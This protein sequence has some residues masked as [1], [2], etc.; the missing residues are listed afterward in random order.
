MRV[1]R[2]GR[3]RR[4]S[5]HSAELIVYTYD[6]AHRIYHTHAV[7]RDASASTAGVLTIA[8]NTWTYPWKDSDNGKPVYVRILNVFR[9]PNTIFTKKFRWTRSTGSEPPT[10]SN[11]A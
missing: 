10:A 7:A 2:N 5:D 4:R 3:C 6:P 11:T 8:G 1:R 9:D